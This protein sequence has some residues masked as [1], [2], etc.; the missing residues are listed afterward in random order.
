MLSEKDCQYC[1]K[2]KKD[3]S[4]SLV[5]SLIMAFL[6]CVLI[7]MAVKSP[8]VITS[9]LPIVSSLRGKLDKQYYAYEYLSPKSQ[10][11]EGGDHEESLLTTELE[12][13]LFH[14]Y[15]HVLAGQWR[16]IDFFMQFIQLFFGLFLLMFSLFSF[17]QSR[18]LRKVLQLVEVLKK[19]K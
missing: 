3:S 11:D 18:R 4:F 10:H 16:S 2:Q 5:S 9:R 1:K 8:E 13:K 12:E 14:D 15:M 7:F 17:I 6:S 19:D